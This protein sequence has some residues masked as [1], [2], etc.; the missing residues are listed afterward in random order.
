MVF[1][2]V[3][4]LLLGATEPIGQRCGIATDTA[5][6]ATETTANRGLTK[7]NPNRHHRQDQL[8]EMHLGV[9]HLTHRVNERSKLEYLLQGQSIARHTK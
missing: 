1:V 4:V 7:S 5:A 2:V 3:A 6:T 9:V 8:E